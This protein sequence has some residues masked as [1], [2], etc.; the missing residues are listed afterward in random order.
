MDTRPC[1]GAD[2]GMRCSVLE[3][4][5]HHAAW[6][7]TY[8][9]NLGAINAPVRTLCGM[10]VPGFAPI[11]IRTKPASAPQLELFL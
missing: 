7:G 5:A 6:D 3:Q 9:P 10:N 8:P 1:I 4:C 2:W 11:V